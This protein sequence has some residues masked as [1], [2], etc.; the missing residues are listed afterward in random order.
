MQLTVEAE[1]QLVH[2]HASCD[3]A[4]RFVVPELSIDPKS[5]PLTIKNV[6]PVRAKFARAVL[7]NTGALK[8]NMPVRVPTM[9][10]TDTVEPTTDEYESAAHCTVVADVQLV[11][12]HVSDPVYEAVGVSNTVPKPS[13]LIVTLP[14]AVRPRFTTAL[15]ETAGASKVTSADCDP[16]WADTVTPMR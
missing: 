6:L 8:V 12:P 1:V 14:P 15:P 11:L 5:R 9:A 16:T 2:R 3:P 13:P 4:A 10:D 7:L